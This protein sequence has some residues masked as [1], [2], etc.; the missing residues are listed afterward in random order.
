[1]TVGHCSSKVERSFH[2]ADVG[3]SIPLN[4]MGDYKAR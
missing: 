3:G 4:V 2:I 1:M